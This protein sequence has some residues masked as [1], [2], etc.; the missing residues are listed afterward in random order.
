MISRELQNRAAASRFIF[1][2][3][4]IYFISV[5]LMTATVL[6][7]QALVQRELDGIGFLSAMQQTLARLPY[8]E[9]VSLGMA[10]AGYGQEQIDSKVRYLAAAYSVMTIAYI[11]LVAA[12]VVMFLRWR[13]I[14]RRVPWSR[15][16]AI[17]IVIIAAMDALFLGV[18]LHGFGDLPEEDPTSPVDFIVQYNAFIGINLTLMS[19]S[20]L[21]TLVM[22]RFISMIG[23]RRNEPPIAPAGSALRRTG[24]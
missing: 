5:A 22:A 4:A 16:A 13:G 7:L 10:R 2:L 11:L 9:R 8:V 17:G 20:L 14:A 1:A 24:G 19:F 21:T 18:G 3:C 6:P 15:Y 23:W 12:A